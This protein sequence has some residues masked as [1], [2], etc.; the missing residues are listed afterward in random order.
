MMEAGGGLSNITEKFLRDHLY[1]GP[2]YL[3]L[4]AA[5]YSIEELGEL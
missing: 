1:D 3:Y 5:A 2:G 4:Q